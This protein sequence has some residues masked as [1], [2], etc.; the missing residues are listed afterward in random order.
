MSG[1]PFDGTAGDAETLAKRINRL[2]AEGWRVV[3][4]ADGPGSA[5]RLRE[6]LAEGGANLR[7][8]DVV[9]APLDR[10]FLMSSLKLAVIGE[11]DLTGRRRVHRRAGAPGGV[12]TSTTI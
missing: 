9:V 4:A 7:P 11:A 3:V 5:R 2:M 1:T 8:A 10:G 6:V 12:R